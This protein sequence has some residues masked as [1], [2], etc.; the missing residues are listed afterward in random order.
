MKYDL[1]NQKFG[2]LTALYPVRKAGRAMWHCRC[3]CGQEYDAT[4]YNLRKGITWHCGCQR[5]KDLTNKKFNSLTALYPAGHSGHGGPYWV[6]RC[7]C[8]NMIE[9]ESSQLTTGNVR[10]CGSSQ[11]RGKDIIGERRGHLTAIRKTGKVDAHR[12]HIYEWRC[13]CGKIVER[14][15]KGTRGQECACPDCRNKILRAQTAKMLENRDE[16][17][18]VN[19]TQ[20]DHIRCGKPTKIN[21]SGIRGVRRLRGKWMASGS[22]KGRSV[23]LG[24]YEDI[25][26]ARKARERFVEERY[27]EAPRYSRE[28]GY[29]CEYDNYPIPECDPNLTTEERK[30]LKAEAIAKLDKIIEDSL[31]K[32]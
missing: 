4:S 20:I 30:K 26:D 6:C 15:V 21:T 17:T 8:G 29:V 13:D 32:K 25:E 27:G 16:E 24:V 31:K 18:G 5:R 7:D 12:N 1:T 11:H 28:A 14:T 10:S 22:I 3:D 19:N 2:L 9:V 23:Y